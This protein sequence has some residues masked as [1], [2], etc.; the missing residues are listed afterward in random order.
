M[1]TNF[2]AKGTP[3]AQSDVAT[4]VTALGGDEATFW[5]LVAVET[6]GFGYLS[7]RRP[8]ILFERHVFHQRTGG[9]YSAAHPDISNPTPGGYIGKAA[10]YDRLRSAIQLDARAALESASWGI[11]QIM[12]YNAGLVGFANVEA[13]VTAMVASEAA[14]LQAFV[15][16]IANQ[17]A[18]AKAFQTRNWTLL[19]RLYNGPNYLKNHYDEQLQHNYTVFSVAANRPNM[20]IRTAQVCLTYLGYNAKG[21]D[22]TLGPGTRAALLAYR[23]KRGQPAGDLDAALLAMLVADAAI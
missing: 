4:A 14:Q 5:S 8:Q 6:H 9:K 16:F 21:V 22:G 11:G 7:D 15:N 20:D 3:I 17:A 19:A 2:A 12:G 10:E 1:L 23:A 18:L 13:M